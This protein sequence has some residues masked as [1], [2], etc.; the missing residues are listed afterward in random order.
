M[1]LTPQQRYN[2][3][4]VEDI[5]VLHYPNE[6]VKANISDIKDYFKSDSAIKCIY[7]DQLI[8]YDTCSNRVYMPTFDIRL[9]KS[10]SWHPILFLRG[11]DFNNDP[12][13]LM[14]ENEQIFQ[15]IL[16]HTFIHHISSEQ[17]LS[18]IEQNE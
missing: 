3:I 2:K 12:L 5:T 10:N 11:I 18:V 4:V 6:K 13:I 8:Q 17:P 9:I 16:K 14:A 7:G 1:E 15:F